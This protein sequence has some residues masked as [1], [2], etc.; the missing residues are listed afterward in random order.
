MHCLALDERM[1]VLQGFGSC[2]AIFTFWVTICTG[3]N[4]LPHTPQKNT[5]T[6]RVGM[7]STVSA[8]VQLWDVL[9]PS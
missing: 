8:A 6:L 9:W 5:R 1:E 2:L 3:E 4:T 7:Q